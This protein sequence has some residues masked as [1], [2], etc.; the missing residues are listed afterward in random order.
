MFKV[1]LLTADYEGW[2]FFSDWQEHVQVTIN[3]ESYK[4]MELQYIKM[5]KLLDQKYK[6]KQTGKYGIT[7]FYNTCDIRYCDDCDDDVQIYHTPLMLIDGK[8]CEEHV[9]YLNFL[10]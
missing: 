1:V 9:K 8:L 6:V 7:S 3:C 10:K 4:E 2:W 5:C